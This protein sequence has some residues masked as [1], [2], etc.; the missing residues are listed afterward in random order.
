MYKFVLFFKCAACW[1]KDI[2]INT[3]HIAK[4]IQLVFED[5]AKYLIS[6][7]FSFR[8]FSVI[9]ITSV[10]LIGWHCW[11]NWR[12]KE[13][14]DSCFVSYHW[15]CCRT[16][17]HWRHSRSRSWLAPAAI[18]YYHIATGTFLP[19]STFYSSLCLLAL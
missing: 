10:V 11:T 9:I 6:S 4:H 15:K 13:F 17:Y 2:C 12:W 3:S 8:Y 19:L 5:N 14:A 7:N 1:Y 18:S 16:N